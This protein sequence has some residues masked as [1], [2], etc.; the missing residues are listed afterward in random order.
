MQAASLTAVMIV[1]LATIFTI[2]SFLTIGPEKMDYSWKF[3]EEVG[4]SRV[5]LP[6]L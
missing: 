6:I 1:A 4:R 3:R 5:D 2:A